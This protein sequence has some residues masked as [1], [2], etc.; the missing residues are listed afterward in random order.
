MQEEQNEAKQEQQAPASDAVPK[1][2]QSTIEF[3][4]GDLD[5]AISFAKAV[6]EL[7]GQSCT[8]DQVAA[9]LGQAPTSGAFRLR[10]S[11]PRVFGLTKNERGTVTLTPLGM[12]I[13][14]AKQEAAARVEA[15][16]HVPLYK[17]IY[18]KY[19]GYTIPPP[20]ALEREMNKLGV[21]SK[22]TDTARQ[23]FDRSSKQA[24]FLWAGPDRLV[25]PALKKDGETASPAE[26]QTK[27]LEPGTPG[28]KTPR[29]SGGGDGKEPPDRDELMRMLLRFLPDEGLD[30]EGLAR[31]LKAAEINLRMAYGIAGEIEM[32]TISPK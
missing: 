14:D 8:L 29:G 23:V 19:K 26:G 10:V 17:A 31:W 20:A 27:P 3:P 4:Y 21:S 25:I 5:T 30:N 13:V 15:F 2:E 24:G 6:H 32:K 22:Q 18:E 9:Q 12:R 11:Y 7:G 1:R 28:A 16:L